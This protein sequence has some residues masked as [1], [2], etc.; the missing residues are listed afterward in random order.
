[1]KTRFAALALAALLPQWRSRAVADSRLWLPYATGHMMLNNTREAL[2]WFRQHLKSNPSDRLALAAYADAAEA[3]GYADLAWRL[4]R[5]LL[6]DMD[7]TRILATPEG[8]AM[9]LRLL[10][11][12]QGSLVSLAQARQLWNGEQATL[13]LWF[14]HFLE[15]LDAGN[16]AA[17]VRAAALDVAAYAVAIELELAVQLADRDIQLARQLGR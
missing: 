2:L 9:Y 4:R 5:Q 1:M 17:L 7:R 3:A 10:A 12:S 6:K 15:R 16:Q 13:Q 11:G 14:E 8:Y